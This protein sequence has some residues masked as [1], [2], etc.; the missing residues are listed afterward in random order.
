MLVIIVK[1]FNWIQLKE[2]ATQGPSSTLL[3]NYF[4]PDYP[5]QRHRQKSYHPFQSAIFVYQFQIKGVRS[6]SALMH[7]WKYVCTRT[8]ST[9]TLYFYFGVW[10]NC[11]WQVT[12]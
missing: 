2:T 3:A 9:T 11:F 1:E 4:P 12:N 5:I 8:L 7:S 10:L 6:A